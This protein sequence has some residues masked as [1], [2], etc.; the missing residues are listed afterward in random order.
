MKGKLN[1]KSR[2]IKYKVNLISYDDGSIYLKVFSRLGKHMLFKQERI[3]TCYDVRYNL[4]NEHENI[5]EFLRY[6]DNL[7][8]EELINMTERIIKGIVDKDIENQCEEDEK[9]KIMKNIS[10]KIKIKDW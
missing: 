10:S 7:S 8:K 4:L 2:N 9:A 6:I 1:Y 3:I 5:K